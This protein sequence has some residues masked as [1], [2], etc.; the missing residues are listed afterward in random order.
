MQALSASK[1]DSV[2]LAFMSDTAMA[3][4]SLKL[5]VTL[6]VSVSSDK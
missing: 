1:L 2:L 4:L 3:Q 5:D 6:P